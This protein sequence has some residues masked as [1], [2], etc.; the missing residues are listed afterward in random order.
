MGDLGGISE[1]RVLAGVWTI[2]DVLM[3]FQMGTKNLL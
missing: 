2:K 3:M 1:A